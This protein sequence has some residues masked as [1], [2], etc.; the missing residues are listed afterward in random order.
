MEG[1]DARRD[2]RM[3][4]PLEI[5]LEFSS[6]KREARISDISLGG[7]YIDSIAGVTEGEI[8]RFKLALPD[9]GSEELAGVVVYV[10]EGVGFGLR[11]DDLTE[12]QKEAVRYVMWANEAES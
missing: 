9:G 12:E 3:G 5:V 8:V 7:C 1:E 2:E 11:F 4:V 6:G 10:H